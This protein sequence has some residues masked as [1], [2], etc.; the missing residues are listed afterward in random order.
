MDRYLTHT[1]DLVLGSTRWADSIQVRVMRAQSQVPIAF[2]SAC[3][4]V[5]VLV[6]SA[7]LTA[8]QVT[9]AAA[10]TT[11]SPLTLEQVL[12]NLEQRNAQRAE[13]LEQFEAK[14]IYRIQYRG[15]PG[16]KDA[17]MVVKASFH[18]PDSKQFTVLTQTG[19]RFVIDHVLKK[20]LESEQEAWKAENGQGMA[21]TR[22]NYDFELAGFVTSPE[23]SQFVLK[24]IPRTKNRFLYRGTIWVDAK[25]F[26]VAR[27]EGEPSKNPSMWIKRTDI[28]HRYMNVN[29]FWLPAENHTESFTRLGGKA[30]L[31]IEYRD[32]KIIKASP[33]S[34]TRRAS[35]NKENSPFEGAVL[36]SPAVWTTGIPRRGTH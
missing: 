16:D 5:L 9:D 33:L 30:T 19:S 8:A 36:D 2:A 6:A 32:Y 11:K 22:Q 13:A 3:Q 1:S 31:S 7:G 27:I 20:L 4:I 34:T 35:Q 26:A 10:S 24:L 17:E 12:T 15:F 18:A 28:E 29:G 25:E 21:L 14:R 23:G